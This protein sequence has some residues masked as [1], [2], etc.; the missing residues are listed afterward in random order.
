MHCKTQY[1]ATAT[2]ISIKKQ[3]ISTKPNIQAQW[4]SIRESHKSSEQIRYPIR[5]P[6][7]YRPA[8]RHED[9]LRKTCEETNTCATNDDRRIVERSI[10]RTEIQRHVRTPF[11]ILTYR[12]LAVPLI[13]SFLF[14]LWSIMEFVFSLS[15]TP[16]RETSTRWYQQV[17]SWRHVL[18]SLCWLSLSIYI[19]VC[20]F[21]AESSLFLSRS[22]YRCSSLLFVFFFVFAFVVPS[23]L[24][25]KDITEA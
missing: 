18:S 11:T 8:T 14:F 4:F 25:R 3:S 24:S 1:P 20:D 9:I 15:L 13:F 2:H 22:T 21:D 19:K 23:F 16:I 6:F 17:I 12:E 5:E 7:S 10:E